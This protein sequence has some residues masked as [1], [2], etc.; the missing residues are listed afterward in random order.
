MRR[1]SFV[2]LVSL[3]AG[4]A[5]TSPAQGYWSLLHYPHHLPHAHPHHGHGLV[6]PGHPTT[7]V[8]PIT[9]GQVLGAIHLGQQIFG[10]LVQGG[11][12]Q[13]NPQPRQQPAE[14]R[15]SA[16]VTTKLTQNAARLDGVVD[17]TNALL[18]LV[19][20][21]DVRQT[22]D[23]LPDVPKAGGGGSGVSSGEKVPDTGIK[24]PTPQE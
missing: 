16:D 2:L 1:L 6:V 10:M 23:S 4:L 22:K 14:P 17:K 9:P 12:Q 8:Q 15:V 11:Q 24:F 20:K 7:P 18:A 5:S 3:L 19:R 13:Q 21:G